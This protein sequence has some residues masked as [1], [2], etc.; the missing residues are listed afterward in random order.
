MPGGGSASLF[1]VSIPSKI[2]DKPRTVANSDATSSARL[3]DLN[4]DLGEGCPWDL[5]LLGKITSAS[6][7]CGFHAGDRETILATLRGA[8]ASRVVVGAHPG[9]PDREGFGR[10]ERAISATDAEA[11]IRE[12]V[13]A[14]RDL[15]GLEG[16]AIRF[17]KPHGALYNQAGHDPEIASGVVA[18]ARVLGLPILG[19]PGGQVERSAREIGVRFLTEG[20][21]DRGYSPDG[22]L[23][24][25]DQPGA[26]LHDPEAIARQVM[27][28]VD[29]EIATLCLHGDNPNSAALADLVRSTLERNDVRV[30]GF[31]E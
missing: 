16:V 7:S 5:A 17:L 14:L 29:R 12:Q 10:R 25:R 22:R 27:A 15:A 24:P 23:L 4:A 11:L 31:F 20:F 30:R 28:L 1:M 3:I 26:I 2:M 6:V 19:Q 21:A 18:A 8:R 9:Y 13:E